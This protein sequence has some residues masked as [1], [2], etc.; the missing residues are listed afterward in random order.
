MSKFRTRHFGL[1]HRLVAYVSTHL[2]GDRTYKMR[3]GLAAGMWRR[4]GLGFLKLRRP[5]TE[6][7]RFLGSLDLTGKVVYDLGSFEGILTLFFARRAGCVIAYEPNPRNYERCLDNVRLNR[8]TN[9]RVFNRGVAAEAGQLELT[10]DPL[11][12]GAASGNREIS[13]QISASAARATTVPV[14]VVRL[15][16]EIETLSLPA[17]DFIKID[18]EGTEFDALRGMNRTLA[19]R[20]PDLFIELHGAEWPDKFANAVSVVGLLEQTGYR[21]Y[22]VENR[23]Y[24]TAATLDRHPPSHL[25]GTRG[26]R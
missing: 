24:L 1:F 19:S 13:R 26:R 5:E 15:D 4:G 2:G 21:I 9:V 25:Y 8:L 17:P 10:L 14:S 7:E 22:D 16:S 12:P 23:R 3:H 20:G 6:E 18:I 11:M